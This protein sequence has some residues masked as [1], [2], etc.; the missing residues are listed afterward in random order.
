M[1][2]SDYFQ[3]ADEPGTTPFVDTSAFPKTYPPRPFMGAWSHFIWFLV[4]LTSIIFQL[5][6][7]E[8]A[9]M[10]DGLKPFVLLRRRHHT[11]G[12]SHG[13]TD[14]CGIICS[15]VVGPDPYPP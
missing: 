8:S 11:G 15:C 3:F 6:A 10:V 12:T 5:S 7:L 2:V 13:I 1:T 4:L 14:D 9:T